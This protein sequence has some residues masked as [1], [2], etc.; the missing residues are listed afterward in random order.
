MNDEKMTSGAQ[1]TRGSRRPDFLGVGQDQP[2]SLHVRRGD[3]QNL[4]EILDLD[5]PS[6]IRLRKRYLRT[7]SR[8]PESPNDVGAIQDF[9]DAFGFPEDLPDL[10]RLTHPDR[11]S[12][13]DGMTSSYFHLRQKGKLPCAH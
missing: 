7:L 13:K 10:S 11:D 9:L 3:G 2:A 12:R 8:F 5:S 1:G 4:I 6:A